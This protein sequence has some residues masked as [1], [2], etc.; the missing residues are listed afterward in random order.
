MQQLMSSILFN[1]AGNQQ[2]NGIR[3][4]STV[5]ESVFKTLH[6]LA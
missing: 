1:E 5:G 2:A 3:Q 4:Q 6:V